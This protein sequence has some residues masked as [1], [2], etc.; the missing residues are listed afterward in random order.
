MAQLYTVV[1]RWGYA[2]QPDDRE[3]VAGPDYLPMW[4]TR[5]TALHEVLHWRSAD[6]A[7]AVAEKLGPHREGAIV[8]VSAHEETADYIVTSQPPIIEASQP[9]ASEP[10]WVLSPS[11]LETVKRIDL[12]GTVHDTFRTEAELNGWRAAQGRLF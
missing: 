1:S 10:T 12:F 5:A 7:R 8:S 9:D 3:A 4:P 2:A 6:E 11:R